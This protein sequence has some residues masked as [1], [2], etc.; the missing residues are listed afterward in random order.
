MEDII[1]KL[2]RA[3]TLMAAIDCEMPATDKMDCIRIEMKFE[4]SRTQNDIEYS[5]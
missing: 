4:H 5:P 1:S 2:N 3:P